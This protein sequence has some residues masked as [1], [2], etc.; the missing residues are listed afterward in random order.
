MKQKT[1]AYTAKHSDQ[2]NRRFQDTETED[3]E[4]C[5][6]QGP[7]NQYVQ[8]GKV[9]KKYHREVASLLQTARLGNRTETEW[10]K[11]TEIQGQKSKTQRQ[12]DTEKASS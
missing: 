9:Q 5:K 6:T 11:G 4:Y 1:T 10:K 2:L 3:P 8:H 7:Q 12:D